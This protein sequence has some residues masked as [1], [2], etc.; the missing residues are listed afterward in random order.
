M[1]KVISFYYKQQQWTTSN[2]INN[3]DEIIKM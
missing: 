3:K 1:Y 2:R